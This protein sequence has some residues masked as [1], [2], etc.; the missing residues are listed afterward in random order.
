MKFF[1]IT[2]QSLGS[3]ACLQIDYKD[4]NII[5]YGDAYY[6]SIWRPIAT[7]EPGYEITNPIVLN[8]TYL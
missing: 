5:T 4:S 7:Y 1:E 2:F 8:H 3:G 6:C